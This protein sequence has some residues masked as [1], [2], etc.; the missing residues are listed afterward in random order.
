MSFIVSAILPSRKEFDEKLALVARVPAIK[1][2]QRRCRGRA[3]RL[4]GLMARYSD[5]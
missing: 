3:L 2:V 4:S 5:K 1:R